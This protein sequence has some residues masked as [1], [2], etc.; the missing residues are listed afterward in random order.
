MIS[1]GT[2]VEG[3]VTSRCAHWGNCL[4]PE[5]GEGWL[6]PA[7][8]VL[9]FVCMDRTS[10]ESTEGHSTRCSSITNY[11]HVVYVLGHQPPRQRE[12]SLHQSF[13]TPQDCYCN[14]FIKSD[15]THCVYTKIV[16]RPIPA[17]GASYYLNAMALRWVWSNDW[18]A[19]YECN[20][21]THLHWY[22]T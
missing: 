14:R 4:S 11:A 20:I 6:V 8:G 1:G 19:S 10:W 7:V 21:M 13:I 15:H 22:G 5:E 2:E 17:S 18:R 12:G 9:C 16:D 3:L